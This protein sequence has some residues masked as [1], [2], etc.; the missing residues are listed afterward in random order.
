MNQT[1]LVMDAFQYIS[2]SPTTHVRMEEH[3][4]SVLT[5]TLTTPVHVLKIY[6][7]KIAVVRKISLFVKY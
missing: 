7:E 2:V 3:A 1:Q 4:L 6:L 5:T